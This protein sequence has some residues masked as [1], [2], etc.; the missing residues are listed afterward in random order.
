[1][2]YFGNGKKW[3][4][5]IDYSFEQKPLNTIGPLT[6]IPDLPDDFLVMNSDVLCNLNF[7]RFFNE[8]VKSKSQ[9]SV[10]ACSRK[11][12]IDFGY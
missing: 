7:K 2:S 10:A 8:H 4:I 6:L 3:N 9:I 11:S 1:M 5:L 12:V